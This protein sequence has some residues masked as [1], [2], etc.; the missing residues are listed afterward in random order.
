MKETNLLAAGNSFRQACDRAIK[1]VRD[2]QFKCKCGGEVRLISDS[3]VLH[4]CH[5]KYAPGTSFYDGIPHFTQYN[6]I[7]IN[8]VLTNGEVRYNWFVN[9][10]RKKEA[11]DGTNQIL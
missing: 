10:E 8:P 3:I 2:E 9:W 1:E 11:I 5:E 4:A 6:R 7:Q